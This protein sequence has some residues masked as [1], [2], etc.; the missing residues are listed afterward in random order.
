YLERENVDAK[1][2][3]QV[4]DELLIEVKQEEADKVK[5]KVIELMENALKLNV[6]L[7]VDANSARSWY[8][9]K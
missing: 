2:I 4:H 8:E 7:K 5:A 9:G 1:L 6:P 3:L